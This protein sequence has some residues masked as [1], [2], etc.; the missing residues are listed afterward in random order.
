MYRLNSPLQNRD[1]VSHTS[2]SL[3]FVG[4]LLLAPSANALKG[5][6]EKPVHINADSVLFNKTKGL[7]VYEGNVSIV[8]G[9]LDIRAQKIE[10]IAP[11]SEIKK[12]SAT[13]SPVSFQQ[14]MDDGKLA[15]GKANHVV[16]QVK[17]KRLFLDGN[18]SISQGDDKF[19]SNHIE[20]SM[21]NGELKAG[22]KKTPGKSRVKA[23][24]YPS[25]KSN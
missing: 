5:D 19:S 20:Y 10:I 2:T 9:S 15:K 25:N 1:I 24:F 22:N 4:L 13:G 16:Y 6:I 3:F 8:Q 14:K 11:N 23:I 12:I 17:E 7:A 18:A 21:R